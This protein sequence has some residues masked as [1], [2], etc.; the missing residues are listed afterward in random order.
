MRSVD[1]YLGIEDIANIT[2]M[3]SISLGSTRTGDSWEDYQS[4]ETSIL[5]LF[6]M[7]SIPMLG[8]RGIVIIARLSMRGGEL[9]T[10]GCVGMGYHIGSVRRFCQ[11]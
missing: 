6:S 3:V 11:M 7:F 2:A 10:R 9:A 4:I 5:F 1:R 8:G